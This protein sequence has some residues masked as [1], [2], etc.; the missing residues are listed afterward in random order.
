MDLLSLAVILSAWAAWLFKSNSEDINR[1]QSLRKQAG[2]VSRYIESLTINAIRGAQ[3]I[4]KN[5]GDLREK[6]NL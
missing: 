4:G 1:E 5:G 6:A 3:E 2:A